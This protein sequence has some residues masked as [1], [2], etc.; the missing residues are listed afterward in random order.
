MMAWLGIIGQIL[1]FMPSIAG[2]ANKIADTKVAL[3]RVEGDRERE[4]LTAELGMLEAQV[5]LQARE[6]DYTQLNVIMRCG[7]A[8]P[9]IIVIWKILVWDQTLQL[10]STPAL[11]Q[12]VWNLIYIVAGFYFVHSVAQLVRRAP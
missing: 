5:N 10:G 12:D 8:L 9:I 6:A 4:R 2:I 11:G 3:A 1:G 7:F